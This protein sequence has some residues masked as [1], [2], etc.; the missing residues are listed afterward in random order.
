MVCFQLSFLLHKHT[1]TLMPTK[2]VLKCP[3]K[4]AIL[5]NK[6]KIFIKAKVIFSKSC[7][8]HGYKLKYPHRFG[9]HLTRGI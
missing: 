6:S 4:M 1:A 7:L 5:T 9:F 8:L 2:Y 3:K